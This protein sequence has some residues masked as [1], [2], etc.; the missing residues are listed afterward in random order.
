MLGAT[1][2]RRHLWRP[3]KPMPAVVTGRARERERE[4]ERERDRDSDR[5]RETQ[6]VF[7]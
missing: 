4:E 2:G 7:S 1:V 3:L 6:R 5:G